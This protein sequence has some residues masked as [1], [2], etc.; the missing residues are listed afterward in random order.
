MARRI[1][2][3]GRAGAA[4]LSRAARPWIVPLAR[5]GYAAKGV[6]YLIVGV[7]AA[8]AVVRGRGETPDQ[9]GALETILEQPFGRV[10]L[11]L[12]AVGL[13]GYVVWR[14]VQAVQDTEGHGSDAKGL[15]L[16]ALYAGSGLVYTGLA[17]A[18]VRLVAGGRGGGDSEASSREWTA[19]LLAQPFGQVLV[20]LA[21]L[22]IL[23][24]AAYQFYEAYTARFEERLDTRGMDGRVR[25]LAVRAGRAG[26][27]ARG[28]VFAIIGLFLLQAALHEDAGE[29]RGLR[30]ALRALEAWPLGPWILTVV[31]LG[32]AT[33]GVYQ[34]VEARYRRIAV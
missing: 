34:L 31:A 32:L 14:F 28:V 21:G 6:V 15:G 10:L 5:F 30:G 12:V 25:A 19:E 13:A 23:G 3:P 17:A 27:A 4:R 11:A 24:F 33:Y 9:E 20:A 1:G 2:T 29:A 22:G 8:L 16:R 18:A 7:L 26:L